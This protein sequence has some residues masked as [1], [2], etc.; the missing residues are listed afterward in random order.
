MGRGLT[1]Y[2]N[3]RFKTEAAVMTTEK[4]KAFQLTRSGEQV[5][6]DKVLPRRRPPGP[7]QPHSADQTKAIQNA[8]DRPVAEQ[9]IPTTPKTADGVVPEITS[10]TPK[11][12]GVNSPL[13]FHPMAEIF[14]LLNNEG[15]KALAD[16][17]AEHGLLD[18]II[19]L[20]G[21]ILD[22]R[23]RYLACERVGVS[24]KFHD[25]VGDDPLGFVISRNVHRRHL[26]KTQ[27]AFAAARAATLPVGANQNTPGLPIGRA[28]EIFDVSER[29]IARAKAI[30]RH[31]AAD[32][33]QAVESGK[34]AISRA[35]EPC[36][37]ADEKQIVALK[38][39]AER[40]RNPQ[41][42]KASA[43]AASSRA[44][45]TQQSAL[46]QSTAAAHET[47]TTP[48]APNAETAPAAVP[49][50][51]KP[52]VGDDGQ[53]HANQHVGADEALAILA[54]FAKF[55][56]ARIASQGKNIIV[57]VT[58]EDADQF[59]SLCDRAKLAIGAESGADGAHSRQ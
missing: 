54:E 29:N 53:V 36:E 15:L 38:E 3:I 50:I 30:L 24:P 27:S 25:Y 17:I 12:A 11:P 45:E 40:K 35:A 14:Q 9:T 57:T 32:L 43:G 52:E 21:K 59:R 1:P 7:A 6:V 55:V 51:E 58:E 4:T 26:T 48:D 47:E 41:E 13:G 5:I 42:K 28:A 34:V 23:C 56:I 39:V 31:G 18:E 2:F 10:A 20:D 22:G 19:L 46:L 8:P 33:V 49:K 16:D 37:L 44:G